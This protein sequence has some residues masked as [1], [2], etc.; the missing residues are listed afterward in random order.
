MAKTSV[1]KKTNSPTA[2]RDVP[3]YKLDIQE[4]K[5]V[6]VTQNVFTDRAQR[7]YRHRIS[8]QEQAK[9][10]DLFKKQGKSERK[11]LLQLMQREL[12]DKLIKEFSPAKDTLEEPVAL[13]QK[14]VAIELK[15]KELK[16]GVFGVID[17][18]VVV[19]KA[20][21]GLPFSEFQRLAELLD[22]TVLEQAALLS[23]TERTMARRIVEKGTLH[24]LDS[25]RLVLLQKLAEHGIEVFE[26]Q[27]KFNRWLRRP[28]SLL[29]GKSP[30]QYLDMTTGF[31]IV[32][33]VLGRLEHGVYS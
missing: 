19:E 5:R 1:S 17:D 7:S 4:D 11:V 30:L 31:G 26:D 9:F 2:S 14:G 29:D 8:P 12:E 13:K 3:G 16:P 20:R 32:D 18:R 33:H 27:G 28:L 21:Q 25:E 15:T 6:R 24:T 22:L 10:L 23:V